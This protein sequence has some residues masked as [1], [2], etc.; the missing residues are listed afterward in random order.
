MQATRRGDALGLRFGSQLAEA[1]S[2]ICST[3]HS[4]EKSSENFGSAVVIFKGSSCGHL[5]GDSAEER[6]FAS[7]HEHSWEKVC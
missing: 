6:D 7:D 4:K 1:A 3:H 5:A 2:S